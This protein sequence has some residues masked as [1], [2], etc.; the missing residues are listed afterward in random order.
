MC[1]EF[2]QF[3]CWLQASWLLFPPSP[4]LHKMDSTQRWKTPLSLSVSL[5]HTHMVLINWVTRS[6]FSLLYALGYTS[7]ESLSVSHIHVQRGFPPLFIAAKSRCVLCRENGRSHARVCVCVCTCVCM[8]VRCH[9][10]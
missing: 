4:L 2:L 9:F 8:F 7:T 10:R 6:F 1:C 3:K 5:S